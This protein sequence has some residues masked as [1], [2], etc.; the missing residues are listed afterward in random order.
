MAW[1][2]ER[3]VLQEGWTTRLVVDD[4]TFDPHPQVTGF[5]VALNAAE[6][7][8]NTVKTYLSALAGFLNWAEEHGVD[9]RR[10][11][12]LDLTRF[13]R[14]LQEAPTRTGRPRSPATVGLALTAVA[15]FLRY[16]A[17]ERII[18]PAISDQLLENRQMHSTWHRRAGE[19]GQFRRTRINALRVNRIE[20]PPEVLSDDQVVAM[21]QLAATARDRFLLRVLHEG[22]PR[23]GETLGL[24]TED[25]HLLPNSRALNCAVAGPHFHVNR[26][27]DNPN[28]AL[29]KS[30]R[31]RHIPVADTFIADYRDYQ[32][33][34]FTSF[35]DRQSAYLFVNYQGPAAGRPMTYS[36]VYKIVTRLGRHCG[37]RATPHMFR[38]SAATTWV[39]A[40]SDID[41]VQAL[42]GHVAPTSTAVYLHASDERLREAVASVHRARV[43]GS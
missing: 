32:H 30:R 39:E 26:R 13:K 10:I 29:A 11:N 1:K 15:E 38:H 9:W 22:G 14:H 8:P 41:V 21:R 36:N 27:R 33:E 3:A 6:R 17:A 2:V 28:G 24:R 37:F 12:V 34:R 25:V 16:C 20:E 7:S 23:I 31:P 5:V 18:D 19:N 4:R 35:G 42:L 43:G 40:G